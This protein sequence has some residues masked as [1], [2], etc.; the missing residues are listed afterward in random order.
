MFSSDTAEVILQMTNGG[1][2]DYFDIT[3]FDDIYGGIIADS[4]NVPAGGEPVEVAHSYP[5]RED[6]SY[7]W[8]VV[9][10]TSAGDPIDFITNTET[11]YL[12]D[13]IGDPLLTIRATTSM[14]KISRSGSVP[15]RIELTNIGNSMAANVRIFEESNG[16]LFE[17]AVVPTG[18]PT[19]RELPYKITEDTTLIFSASY[20]DSYGQERIAT[21]EPLTITIGPGGQRPETVD[22]SNSIIGGI[23]AQMQHSEL[24]IGLLFGSIT[25]L[26]VLIVVLLITS[27]R[28]RIKRK[29]LAS[30]RK[31]RIKEEM[32]KTNRFKPLR[33]RQDIKSNTKK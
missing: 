2:I 29:E 12:D 11:V 24:F 19:A 3:V 6:S 15:V 28:I 21:A 18:A 17:L 31:Q 1:N 8:R 4:V 10:R 7:R 30:A 20:T 14:P 16:Q 23:A 33:L 32:A 5:I 26:V 9:G 27:R 25:V 22:H 13:P